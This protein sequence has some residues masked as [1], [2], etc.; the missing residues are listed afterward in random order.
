[1]SNINIKLNPVEM[2]IYYWET[3]SERCK[4][5]EK[6]IIGLAEDQDME[7][8]YDEEFS[9]DSFRKVLSAI[10]NHELVNNATKKESRFWS[11]NM[12]MLEDLDNM[13][14]MVATVKTLNLDYLKDKIKKDITLVFVPGTTEETIID[15]DKL[16]INFFKISINPFEE[17]S[18]K[19]AG[20]DFKKYIEE[21]I[22][23]M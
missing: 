2:M 4:V 9:K 22:L 15:G 13:R 23:A 5:N 1:M 11:L 10:C 6:Y 3:I 18:V 16:L 7:A 12:W 21:K 20:E 8:L 19:F 17:G 14:K